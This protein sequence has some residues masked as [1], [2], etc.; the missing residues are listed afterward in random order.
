MNKGGG[1]AVSVSQGVTMYQITEEGVIVGVSL[2]G[3]KFYKDS[4]LN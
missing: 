1:N 4:E 3:A 2:T